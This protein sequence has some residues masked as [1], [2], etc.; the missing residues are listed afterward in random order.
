MN[1]LIIKIIAASFLVLTLAVGSLF[2][3]HISPYLYT[4]IYGNEETEKLYSIYVMAKNKTS[5][6]E[7]KEFI[8]NNSLEYVEHPKDRIISVHADTE[9]HSETV[10]IWHKEGIPTGT[11]FDDFL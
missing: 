11:R 5:L 7:I 3:V 1:K 4:K 2:A 10:V 6:N 8:T 9:D